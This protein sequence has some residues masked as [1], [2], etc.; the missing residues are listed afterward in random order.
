M[1]RILR[2]CSVLLVLVGGLAAC[3]DSAPPP[4]VAP[5]VAPKVEVPPPPIDP[6]VKL[7][8]ETDLAK[9]RA[10]AEK[11]RGLKEQG[12]QKA[13]AGGSGKKEF[14]EAA[15]TMTLAFV[16]MGK[17]CE[18]TS[19]EVSLTGEQR[20][21]YIA[22]IFAERALWLQESAELGVLQQR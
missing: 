7:A 11:A 8:L 18:P 4:K 15:S 2:P 3:G 21:Y 14:T 5:S 12:M 16:S 6:A 9:A 1:S 22:P 17:W 10:L 19:K 13:R 20:A